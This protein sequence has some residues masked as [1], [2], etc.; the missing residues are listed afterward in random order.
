DFLA[1]SVG[2]NSG[3]LKMKNDG[4]D[5]YVPPQG[6]KTYICEFH[7]GHRMVKRYLGSS[8]HIFLLDLPRLEFAA[9]I[10]KSDYVTVCLLGTDIDKEIVRRFLASEEVKE[11]MPPLWV[12]PNQPCHCAP[13]IN[14]GGAV[15]PFADRTVFIGDCATTRLYKDG[16]GAAYRTSKAAAVTAVFDGI[17]AESFRRKYWPVCKTI[18]SDN[19]IGKLMFTAGRQ[20][21]RRARARRA[22]WQTLVDE[23]AEDSAKRLSQVM[24]DL[25]TGSASYRSVAA[26]SLHPKV[27]GALARN[28]VFKRKFG[29]GKKRRRVPMASGMT[30]A[31]GKQYKDGDVIFNQGDTGDCMFVIQR[32]GVELVQREGDQ[33]FV[34]RELGK[35]D[36]FGEMALFEP[37][38]R[39]VT[40]RSVGL[41]WI[42]TLERDTLLKRIHEDPSLA[43]RLIQQ[44]AY[45]VRELE[46]SLIK[47]SRVAM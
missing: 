21:Q 29:P 45:R 5:G 2:I 43:F 10:P 35:G 38:T 44:L 6:T 4:A 36:F 18:Q 28:M 24:W 19:D 17:S 20:F 30:G 40:A 32:G 1:V 8:M 22:V 9:L 14:V 47:K 3:I 42:Y 26:R 33:E 41:S 15:R 46:R 37:V 12:P 7:I 31:L 16:I 23:Q 25:F 34:L 11:C 39:P 13:R 27:W